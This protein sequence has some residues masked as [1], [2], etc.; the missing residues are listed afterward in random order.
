MSVALQRAYTLGP[1]PTQQLSN[2]VKIMSQNQAEIIL[3]GVDCVQ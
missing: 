2:Q 1:P 3:L